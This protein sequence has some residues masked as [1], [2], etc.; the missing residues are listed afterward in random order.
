MPSLQ[1]H[2]LRFILRRSAKFGQRATLQE[3]REAFER[4]NAKFSKIAAGTGVEELGAAG[5]GADGLSRLGQPDS[6]VIL[7]LHG[8]AYTFASAR[9][10][11]GF[12]SQIIEA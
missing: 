5:C 4:D 12:V 2:L 11:R 10:H 1:T 7:Y 3:L 9:S 8:G 6:P